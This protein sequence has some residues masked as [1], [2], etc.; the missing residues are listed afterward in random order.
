MV[1][2]S[3]HL[4]LILQTRKLFVRPLTVLQGRWGDGFFE[5]DYDLDAIS[6]IFDSELVKPLKKDVIRLRL[7]AW[8][9]DQL[10]KKSEEGKGMSHILA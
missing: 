6:D 10:E 1:C 8:E 9:Q 4:L 3:Y 2:L 5:G 7:K